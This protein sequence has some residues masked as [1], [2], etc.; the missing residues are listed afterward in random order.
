MGPIYLLILSPSAFYYEYR[1]HRH[2][3]AGWGEWGKRE[4]ER[5]RERENENENESSPS[6]MLS[7]EPSWDSIHDPAIIAW[8][9]IKSRN[10]KRLSHPVAPICHPVPL[11]WAF[12]LFLF[13]VIDRHVLVLLLLDIGYFWFFLILCSLSLFLICWVSS[14]F[15]SWNCLSLYSAYVLVVFD[16]WVLL[17]L[18]LT[19]SAHRS[20][21]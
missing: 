8:T 12:I 5:E 19:T 7:A 4:I 2:G 11:I 9:E 10:L 17:G 15:H 20:L 16:L 6:S 18:H 21:Y 14:Q 1:E 3:R 13:K